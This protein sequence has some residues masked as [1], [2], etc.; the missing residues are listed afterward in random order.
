MI[1]VAGI[2][3]EPPLQETL[4]ALHDLRA[5]VLVLSQRHGTDTDI[6]FAVDRAGVVDTSRCARSAPSTRD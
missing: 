2:P 1:L 5:D 3:S 4:D 6:A